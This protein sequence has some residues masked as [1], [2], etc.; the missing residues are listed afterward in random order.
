MPVRNFQRS[1]EIAAPIEALR[2]FHFAEGA[3]EK[4][5]PP[6]ENAEVVSEA[7]PMR[8]GARATIR[9]RFGPFSKLWIAE[10]EI[11]EDG[12][13]D[14]QIEG[15]FKSWEHRHTFAA[16]GEDSSRLTDSI[17]YEVPF[18]FLGDLFGNPIVERKLDRMF[19]YR[20]EATRRE[21]EHRSDPVDP[22]T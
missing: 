16:T 12:F 8:D 2:E 18:G 20:H 13:I 11:I 14:R 7:H 21:L 5:S 17:R 10:H 19:E 3:F 15:P 9:I 1:C 22:A 4:L 6:W